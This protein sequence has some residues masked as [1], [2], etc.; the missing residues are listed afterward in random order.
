MTDK[1]I[2]WS[3]AIA[4]NIPPARLG[5]AASFA[6]MALTHSHA[7]GDAI[8]H[9]EQTRESLRSAV[10]QHCHP[11][12]AAFTAAAALHGWDPAR[13]NGTIE[14]GAELHKWA[15]QWLRGEGVAAS[16]IERLTWSLNAPD[17]ITDHDAVSA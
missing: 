11:M 2:H 3:A 15:W 13:I 10:D 6:A 16:V 1:L 9:G 4:A 14:D 5:M 12:I 7:Y 8:C 17:V